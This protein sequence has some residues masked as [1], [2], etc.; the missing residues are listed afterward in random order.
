MRVAKSFWVCAGATDQ[1]ITTIFSRLRFRRCFY[2]LARFKYGK[3]YPILVDSCRCQ[4]LESDFRKRKHYQHI[5]GKAV[6]RSNR[7]NE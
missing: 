7:L 3:T 6:S 1:I 4:L 5:A 2:L